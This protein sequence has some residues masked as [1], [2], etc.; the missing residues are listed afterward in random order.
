[1][2][3]FEEKTR[4]AILEKE[5]ETL[6]EEI[7]RLR[8]NL[9]IAFRRLDE[10]TATLLKITENQGK[11]AIESIKGDATLKDEIHKAA[12]KRGSSSGKIWGVITSASVIALLEFLQRVFNL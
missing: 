9:G 11:I 1:M 8:D 10:Q 5:V 2:N 3:E 6:R 4:F 12:G 7:M